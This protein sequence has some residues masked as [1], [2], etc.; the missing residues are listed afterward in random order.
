MNSWFKLLSRTFI[1]L[2][3]CSIVHARM[4][5]AQ[6]P[7]AEMMQ[8][9]EELAMFQKEIDALPEKEKAAFYQSMEEAAKRIDDMAKTPEG[10]ERLERLE[11][12]E[13]SDEELNKLLDD[14]V[15]PSVEQPTVVEPEPEVEK[16]Q[17][18][19][20]PKI[21]K[22]ALTT[23]QQK[24]ITDITELVTA[25]N[26]FIVKAVT[27]T[28]LPG[29]FTRWQKKNKITV[30]KSLSWQKFKTN[31]EQ[32]ITQLEHLL[33]QDPKTKAYAHL[34]A[35]IKDQSLLN[36]LNS[37]KTVLIENN[38]K[39]EPVSP[40][41]KKVSKESKVALQK[42][43]NKYEE[44]LTILGLM[45]EVKKLLGIFEPEAKKLQQEEEKS[46]KKAEQES[47]KS[48]RPGSAIVAG[49]AEEGYT[50]YTP[51][52][53]YGDY[54][55]SPYSSNVGSYDYGSSYPSYDSGF[56][57]FDKNS[58]SSSGR[59]GKPSG[60]GSSL[61]GGSDMLA[62]NEEEKG[63]EKKNGESSFDT[64]KSK[65]YGKKSTESTKEESAEF[66]ELKEATNI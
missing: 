50:P 2:F 28:D 19:A 23:E 49:S 20:K 24:V 60:G 11:R 33:H 3:L 41:Q 14:L 47:K 12:G 30:D 18:K 45:E 7:D 35:L 64:S 27:I 10:R 25:T 22:P 53:S 62:F 59:G 42:N 6:M 1:G 15:A 46:R 61:V 32:F 58:P 51:S 26:V 36:N 40:L 16:P 66:K 5:M 48:R 54:D 13:I 21:T 29:M 38:A 31:I 17:E 44:A 57:S 63:K 43:I 34:D 9:E 37:I 55:Y 8:I 65:E 56:S 4:D 39:I 52:D